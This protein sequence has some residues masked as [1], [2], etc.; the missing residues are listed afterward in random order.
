LGGIVAVCGVQ[1]Q[2]LN[3]VNNYRDAEA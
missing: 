3:I 2:M 1:S